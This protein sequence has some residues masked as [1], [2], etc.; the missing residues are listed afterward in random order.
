MQALNER[1]TKAGWPLV[2]IADCC[3][4]AVGS[5]GPA[6]PNGST[7]ALVSDTTRGLGGQEPS[8]HPVPTIDESSGDIRKI[9][10]FELPRVSVYSTRPGERASDS[11]DLVS[12]LA[13]GLK[14]NE[15]TGR[16]LADPGFRTADRETIHQLRL[17]DWLRFGVT[18]MS[19]AHGYQRQAQLHAGW[20]DMQ[21]TMVAQDGDVM[22]PAK[23][24]I[25]ES[26]ATSLLEFWKRQEGDGDY[27]SRRPFVGQPL[28]Q[29]DASPHKSPRPWCGGYVANRPFGFKLTSPS[30]EPGSPRVA[31]AL[32]LQVELRAKTPGSVAFDAK[33]VDNNRNWWLLTPRGHKLFFA[34]P[35]GRTV[36]CVVPLLGEPGQLLNYFAISDLPEGG[37]LLIRQMI[38]AD[39]KMKLE[40]TSARLDLAARWWVGVSDRPGL[41]SVHEVVERDDRT[42]LRLLA[43]SENRARCGGV[44]RPPMRVTG[45]TN[46]VPALLPDLG[47]EAS[48][49]SLAPD[50]VQVIVNNPAPEP[51]HVEIE[52][53]GGGRN[54]AFGEADIKAEVMRATIEFPVSDSGTADFM[55]ITPNKDGL[56]VVEV[57]LEP[58][59][60]AQKV[61]PTVHRGD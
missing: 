9:G 25:G 54:L 53:E 41:T 11:D 23:N 37:S 61:E 28:L 8:Q 1:A 2:I 52:L 50:T 36:W 44:L 58:A 22:V 46:N 40:A 20:P 57:W 7:E 39:E 10:R 56:E 18:R 29:F 60:P 6:T 51:I 12:R 27:K 38:L 49:A 3:R 16:F 13:E 15:S 34:L 26:Q 14:R 45:T 47:N 4:N 48:S 43:R 42:V 19:F 59:P 32:F 35:P 5:Q 31:R 21:T 30:A 24:P 17:Y 33:Y 55:S